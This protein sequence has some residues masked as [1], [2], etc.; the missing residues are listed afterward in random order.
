MAA[1]A[2]VAVAPVSTWASLS[3]SRSTS[4]WCVPPKWPSLCTTSPGYLPRTS[5]RGASGAGASRPFHANTSQARA[6]L[7]V[8]PV[9]GS[10]VQQT[11]QPRAGVCVCALR[12]CGVGVRAFGRVGWPEGATPRVTD[13]CCCRPPRTHFTSTR[14]PGSNRHPFSWAASTLS[15]RNI[16]GGT[17]K[18]K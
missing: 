10:Q 1:Q 17:Q 5:Q 18:I 13:H 4:Y 6:L 2:P 11:S 8:I 7:G 12:V 16:W 9:H 15:S 3:A 14:S